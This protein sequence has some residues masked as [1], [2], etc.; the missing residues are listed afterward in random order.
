MKK[1]S[2]L[3]VALCGLLLFLILLGV[4]LGSANYSFA[5]VLQSFGETSTAH[6]II[7]DIRLPRVLLAAGLG[8][9]LAVAGCLL[10]AVMR[11]P[12]ADP[13][14]IGISSG[15]GTTATIIFLLAP[16]LVSSIPTF[17]FIG[18]TLTCLLIYLI[19]WRN[20][21]DPLRIILAGVAINSVLGGVNAILMLLNNKELYG[22]LSWMNGSLS[23]ADWSQVT[24]LYS[25]GALGLILALFCIRWANL[26]QFNEEMAQN[27]GVNTNLARFL[28][29]IVGSYLAA[30]T[31]AVVGIVGFVGLI[32]PHLVRLFVGANYKK[33][34]PLSLISGACIMVFGD[35][36]GRFM[37]PSQ[38]IPVGIIMAILGGPFFLYLL[39]NKGVI[40]VN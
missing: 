33:V 13:G 24:L 17:A 16:T 5:Q 22:V 34:I 28:L 32:T 15:A 35:L 38:E 14:I 2:L 11:N 18:A 7:V 3:F 12:L 20:G 40:R 29:S 37:I 30:I 31:V 9:C 4:S 36:V 10:Q 39:C 23:G 26:L 21:I 8:M 19:S 1:T 27:F 6:T 25:Y